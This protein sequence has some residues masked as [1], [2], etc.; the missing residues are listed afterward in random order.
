MQQ[1]GNQ[2]HNLSISDSS[3]NNNKESTEF[4]YPTLHAAVDETVTTFIFSNNINDTNQELNSYSVSVSDYSHHNQE[5][6]HSVHSTPNDY[7]H[8]QGL[9]RPFNNESESDLAVETSLSDPSLPFK[10]SKKALERLLLYL[11]ENIEEV[12]ALDKRNGTKQKLW[13]G[14][15]K[16]VCKE[17][18]EYNSKRCSIKWKNVKQNYI[19][20]MSMSGK[21]NKKPDV[22][23][24]IEI[25]LLK[26]SYDEITGCNKRKAPADEEYSSKKM[27]YTF[28]PVYPKKSKT[29]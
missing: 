23:E 6:G 20:W 4:S 14:A 26:L 21:N 29:L 24:I 13:D 8:N 19:K 11:K 18:H 9:I 25:E 1:L 16:E 2:I 28:V 12:R 17:G 15:S 22:E 3:K 27:D 5:L 7:Y 10:W